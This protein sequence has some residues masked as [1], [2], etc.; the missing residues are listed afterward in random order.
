MNFLYRCLNNIFTR[1]I[2]LACIG[3]FTV[4][5]EF[6]IL[7]IR[8]ENPCSGLVLRLQELI[9]GGDFYSFCFF[10]GSYCFSVEF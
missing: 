5:V 6:E 10:L 8:I 2:S 9:K 7:I 4:G 1:N 3:V